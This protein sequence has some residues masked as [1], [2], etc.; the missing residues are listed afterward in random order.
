MNE[1]EVLGKVVEETAK[2]S[3]GKIVDGVGNF[4]G[5]ICMPMAGELGRYFEDRV[6]IYRLKNIHKILERVQKEL[7][8]SDCGSIS[9]KLLISYTEKASLCE[10]ACVQKMWA[11]LLVGELKRSGTS[12]ADLMYYD[13]LHSLNS[14]QARLLKLIYGDD[15]IC[16]ARQPLSFGSESNELN[17]EKPLSYTLVQILKLSPDPLNY[18]IHNSNHEEII[19]NPNDHSL[20]FEYVI[21]NIA[22]LQRLGLIKKYEIDHVKKELSIDPTIMGL[23][24]YM[25][26]TGVKIYPL[27]AYIVARKY[28]LEKR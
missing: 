6:H 20:A 19:S 2:N 26:C 11:G 8:G 27:A 13:M 22:G 9:P 14:Y 10:D 16:Y 7:E 28:W 24:L 17:L 23:D 18:I 4:L 3:I 12:D 21:P 15:R 25:N 1:N 5:K